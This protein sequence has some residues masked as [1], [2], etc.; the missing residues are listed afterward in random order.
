VELRDAIGRRRMVRAF[1]DEPV[2]RALLAD[3]CDLARR[4]PSAGNS[5]GSEF[6]VLVGDDARSRYWDLTLP[7]PRR[8]RFAWPGLVVAPALVIVAVRPSSYVERYAE[9]DKATTGLGAGEEAWPVPFW[10]VDA[11]AAIEHLLLGV[12]DVGL[13]A[14]MFGLFGHERAVASAFGVPQ[15]RRLVA[16]IAIG[17]PAEDRPGRSAGRPR[18]PLDEVVHH[19]RW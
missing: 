4:A 1:T 2:E 10:W 5:Q 12:V 17:H 16:T 6:L 8:A 15:D 13:G 18:R 19:D 3:L 9:A 11:G 14:C 7:E